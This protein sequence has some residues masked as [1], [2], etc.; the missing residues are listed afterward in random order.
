MHVAASN[1]KKRGSECE[2]EQGGVGRGLE[3]EGEMVQLQSSKIKDENLK[4]VLFLF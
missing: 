2:Q 1:K 3:G 4:W